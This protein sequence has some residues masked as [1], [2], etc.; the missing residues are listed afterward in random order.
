MTD[1]R[2]AIDVTEMAASGYT[3]SRAERKR[4]LGTVVKQVADFVNETSA[5]TLNFETSAAT[6]K[7]LTGRGHQFRQFCG[8]APNPKVALAECELMD[9]I[10]IACPADGTI[11]SLEE[12]AAKASPSQKKRE[13]SLFIGKVA[14]AFNAW[15]RLSIADD[16]EEF[17]AVSEGDVHVSD[18]D[19]TTFIDWCRDCASKA[20]FNNT[21]APALECVQQPKW[22][23]RINT[24]SL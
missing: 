1:L 4:L 10:L 22:I 21:M 14:A 6:L 18:E 16:S 24:K 9:T 19:F 11:A 12:C 17:R 20:G 13:A 3:T 7:K 8:H 23:L 2:K 15:Q 5:A